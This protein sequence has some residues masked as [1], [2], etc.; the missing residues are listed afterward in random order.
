MII[1]ACEYAHDQN[2]DKDNRHAITH[3][4]LIHPQD[5]AR[6][7]EL[8]IIA[9]VQ[10]Y[11]HYKEEGLFYE[12]EIP[13]LGEERANRTY[14]MKSFFDAGIVVSASSD[15]P[16]SQP[17]KPL[18]AIQIG[19][20]RCAESGDPD[21]I[22]NPDERVTVNQMIAAFTINGAY[23]LFGE[24]VYGSI[25]VG[26][27]ADLIILDQNILEI[28]PVKIG[29]VNVLQTLLAGETIYKAN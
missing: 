8:N 17:P 11:W 28:D 21:T 6:M 14:P 5:I 16:V 12:I 2:G 19:V 26:K 29:S 22:K 20:T 9:S 4:Q 23:Q 13:Y 10:P 3:L 7:A 25:E 24:D 15:Y 18:R 27:N 1:D